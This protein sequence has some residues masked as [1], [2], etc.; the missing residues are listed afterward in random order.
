[1]KKSPINIANEGATIDELARVEY[2]RK[3][4]KSIIIKIDYQIEKRF[5]GVAIRLT[6]DDAIEL[7]IM[8]NELFHPPLKK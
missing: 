3:L 1:M 5:A 2:K 8:L 4:A 6:Y 7:K